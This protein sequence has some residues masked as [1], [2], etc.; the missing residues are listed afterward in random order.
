VN[1]LLATYIAREIETRDAW[2]GHSDQAEKAGRPTRHAAK[3]SQEDTRLLARAG[4]RRSLRREQA[5]A[6][7][8]SHHRI[9]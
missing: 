3:A 8:L 2:L 5:S 1:E 9:S 4:A 7:R 6:L